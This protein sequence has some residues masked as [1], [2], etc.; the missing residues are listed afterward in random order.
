[1]GLLS[2]SV[3]IS[4]FNVTSLPAKVDFEKALFQEIEPG[5]EQRYS[6]G[7]IPM[8]L[9]EPYEIGPKRYAFRVRMDRMRA[10]PT[11]L[12]ERFRQLVRAEVDGGAPFINAKRR[13]ELRELAEEELVAQTSPT[14]KIIEGVID[15]GILYVASTA[16]AYLGVVMQLLR[17]V[18]VLVEPKAPW[19][20]RGDTGFESSL[21]PA[22]D[23][24]ESVLGCRLLKELVGDSEVTIEP[25]KGYIR[26]QTL[27]TKV[28]LSGAVFH[29]LMHYLEL[30]CEILVANMIAGEATF[31]FDALAYRISNLKV[32]T[33]KHDH[34]T[35]QL[36]ERLEKIAEVFELLDRKF[37][38]LGTDMSF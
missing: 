5:S 35:E 33:G 21:L 9:G 16:K 20:D 23:P 24:G 32:E 12:R 1:M 30:D 34:W 14:S 6:H 26:V 18:G 2:G 19:I 27:D 17:S 25:E 10:D 7:F 29:E 13:R 36:D 8:D 15:G 37:F 28:T 31:R 38:E 3:S 4:R 11:L 22:L